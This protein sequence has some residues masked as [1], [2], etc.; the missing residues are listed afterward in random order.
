MWTPWRIR[1]AQIFSY[2]G[3]ASKPSGRFWAI[4]FSALL[5]P[6]AAAQGATLTPITA[7]EFSSGATLI[8]FGTVETNEVVDGNMIEDVSFGFTV[9][10]MPSNDATIASGPG[11]TNNITVANIEGDADGVLSMLFTTPISRLGYGWASDGDPSWS[12]IQLFD[13]DDE[14]LGSLTFNGVLDPDFV[15]GFAGVYSDVPF[16]RADVTWT[17]T[18]GTRF[19]LDN[20]HFEVIPEASTLSMAVLGVVGGALAVRAQRGRVL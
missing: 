6:I 16:V 17:V 1:Q 18:G 4:L 8:D 2:H 11:D 10:G 20:V 5:I 3:F 9:N 7:D 15:G 12:V 19:A 14:S 13:E